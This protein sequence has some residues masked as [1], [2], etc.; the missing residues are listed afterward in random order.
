MA[1]AFFYLSLIILWLLL[2]GCTRIRPIQP[3]HIIIALVTAA[4]SLVYDTLLG[5]YAGLYYYI[6]PRHSIYYMILGGALIYPP[7]N[8][9]YLLFLPR[10]KYSASMY[11]ILWIGVM[12]V[13]EYASVL[14]GSV[15]FTGWNPFPWS[16]VTYV[17]TYLWVNLLYRYLCRH[18]FNRSA[19]SPK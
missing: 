7:A 14:A 1:Y 16:P 6:S 9:I 18:H 8:I 11:S 19:A 15:V 17:G 12:M 13:F 5:E 10:D 3:A 4:V 2:Y